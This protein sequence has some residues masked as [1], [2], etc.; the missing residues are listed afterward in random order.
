MMVEENIMTKSTD[1][2]EKR[3]GIGLAGSLGLMLL[4]AGAMAAATILT[5][6]GDYLFQAQQAR[7]RVD[8]LDSGYKRA[9]GLDEAVRT[10]NSSKT[11]FLLD[12]YVCEQD[13]IDTS[14]VRIQFEGSAEA[15]LDDMVGYEGRE[16]LQTNGTYSGVLDNVSVLLGTPVKTGIILGSVYG[17]R[18]SEG[19]E[20]S[21]GDLG[22]TG[23][24]EE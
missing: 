2:T 9:L 6:V 21:G 5:P 1:S 22:E 4:G 24:S 20:C 11:Q 7:S 19:F 23:G 8:T 3:R 14:G 15:F 13:T 12:Q 10:G 16:F 17:W 18:M